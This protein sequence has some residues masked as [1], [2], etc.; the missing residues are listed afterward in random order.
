MDPNQCKLIII[1][2]GL[3]SKVSTFNTIILVDKMFIVVDDLTSQ[4]Y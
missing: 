2:A 3:S 1:G 4:D